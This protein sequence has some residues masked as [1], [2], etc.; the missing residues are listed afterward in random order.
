MARP[1]RYSPSVAATPA[2]VTLSGRIARAS[3]SRA[4]PGDEVRPADD[5]P[6]LRP[7]D[8]LVAA[9]RHEVGAGRQALGRHG[10]MGQAERGRVEQRPA[11]QVV[12]DD[13]AVAVGESATAAGRAPR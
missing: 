10:L 6:G 7:A 1:A 13:R 8:Q 12:D 2:S 3:G 5:E 9:E 11:P 4:H